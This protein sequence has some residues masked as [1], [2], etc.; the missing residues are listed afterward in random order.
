MSI[1]IKIL[2]KSDKDFIQATKDSAGFDLVSTID[3]DLQPK[4]IKLIPTGIYWNGSDNLFMMIT[5][6]SGMAKKGI[7]VNN[8]PAVVDSD[9]YNEIFVMLNNQT[10]E[11]YQIT[12]GDRIAQAIFM[13][14]ITPII[15][16]VK[17]EMELDKGERTGGFGSTGR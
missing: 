7:V 8:A 4:E 10:S 14:Y 9:Y 13:P 5:S 17:N 15:H 6:R 2:N 12:K 16:Y 3:Y 11:N 1:S